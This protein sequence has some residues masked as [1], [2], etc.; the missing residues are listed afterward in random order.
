MMLYECM[1]D[2]NEPYGQ[3][4]DKEAEERVRRGECARASEPWPTPYDEV[5]REWY[6]VRRC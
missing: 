1:E 5:Y 2:G 6:D 4:S 3:L